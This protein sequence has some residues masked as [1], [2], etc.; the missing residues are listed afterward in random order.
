MFFRLY[1]HCI[2][3]TTKRI[4]RLQ[5]TTYRRYL[6]RIRAVSIILFVLVLS[7]RIETMFGPRGDG[8]LEAMCDRP[9][10][11]QYNVVRLITGMFDSSKS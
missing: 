6:R 5:D 9:Y 3:Q 11:T 7:Q 8:D 4:K 10:G 1:C 2:R